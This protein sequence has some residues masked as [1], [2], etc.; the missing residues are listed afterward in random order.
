MFEEYKATTDR[1]VST[2]GKT[3]LVV[4]LAGDDF[5]LLRANLAEQYGPV[6]LG[7]ERGD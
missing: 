3:R 1:L 6:R 5:S 2:F 4:D 7:N